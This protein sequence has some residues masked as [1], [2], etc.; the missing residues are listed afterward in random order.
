MRKGF[1]SVIVLVA[2]VVA[3]FGFFFL[4]STNKESKQE[5]DMSRQLVAQSP[6]PSPSA[7][8][9]P[10]QTKETTN[11]KTYINYK[12]S[13]G[14]KYPPNLVITDGTGASEDSV[15]FDYPEGHFG[16]PALYIS[17]MPDPPAEEHDINIYNS[18]PR[19]I[20]EEVYSLQ[21]GG[22][23]NYDVTDSLNGVLMVKKN[24][25]K[26]LPDQVINGERFLVIEL[27]EGYGGND[28]RLFLKKNNKIYMTGFAYNRV[29]DL[30]LFNNFLA[31][32]K[33][34]Q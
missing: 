9:E 22:E 14:I 13:Y 18:P 3:A 6:S 7:N 30:S 21:V 11:W 23:A 26:R 31:T 34:A 2:L 25:Y 19:S 5:N 28:R 16:I 10:Q 32:F 20:V 4:Y 1:V 12:N 17:V 27:L 8:P 33:F 24:K 15:I 29:S